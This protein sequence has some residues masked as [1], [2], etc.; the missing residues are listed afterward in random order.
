[1]RILLTFVS[2]FFSP[3][4]LTIAESLHGLLGGDGAD[5]VDSDAESDDAE[6]ADAAG[7]LAA[8]PSASASGEVAR[9]GV[10]QVAS[11][12][13]REGRLHPCELRVVSPESDVIELFLSSESAAL[14][15]R[16]L[17]ADVVG[18]PPAVDTEEGAAAVA[19]Q[20]AVQPEAAQQAP[21]H[22]TLYIDPYH[23]GRVLTAEE[24]T[25]SLRTMDLSATERLIAIEPTPPREVVKRMLRNLVAAASATDEEEGDERG[26]E[27][28][29]IAKGFGRS[30]NRIDEL[31]QWERVLESV[32]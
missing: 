17:A 12:G 10:I 5:D 3:S 26:G 16:P 14:T 15:F 7:A 11:P 19:V 32:Q 27:Q 23:E 30:A 31:W 24:C 1:M 20:L 22:T 13:F 18:G 25:A 28:R 21:Q 8:S 2:P 6:H 4:L 29:V 9:K